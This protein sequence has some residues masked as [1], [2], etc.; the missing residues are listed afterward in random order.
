MKLKSGD[1][2]DFVGSKNIR[3]VIRKKNGNGKK[4]R[5]KK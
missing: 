2:F 1:F 4:K 3:E 5:E